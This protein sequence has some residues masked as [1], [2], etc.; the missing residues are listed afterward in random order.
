MSTV[1]DGLR[2]K[3]LDEKIRKIIVDLDDGVQVEVRQ[4]SIGQMLD[5]VNDPDNK[6]RMAN[7][8]ISCCFVPGTDD[9]IFEDSDFDVL[10]GL[11]AG[12]YY[13]KLMDAINAQLLP[14]ELKEAGKGSSGTP[15]SS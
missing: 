8:L 10:M 11:P 1:R 6:K 13:Q 9:P 2:K 5:T 14:M 3:I 7:Y 15:T 4:M 12:G